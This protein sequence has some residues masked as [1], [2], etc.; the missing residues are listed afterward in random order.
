MN[1]PTLSSRYYSAELLLLLLFG[2]IVFSRIFS[3]EIDK[4]PWLGVSI[5]EPRDMFRALGILQF[6]VFAYMYIEW[7]QCGQSETQNTRENKRLAFAILLLIFSVLLGYP[8]FFIGSYYERLSPWWLAVFLSIACFSG[9]V[10]STIVCALLFIRTK[11]ETRRLGLPKVPII[12]KNV[13]GVGT[14]IMLTICSVLYVIWRYTPFDTKPTVLWLTPVVF[15]ATLIGG[16]LSF[17]APRKTNNKHLS[18]GSVFNKW[19]ETN[20]KCDYL[21]CML[22]STRLAEFHALLE[23]IPK[24]SSSRDLQKVVAEA[25]K[26]AYNE[27]MQIPR[28]SI[29]SVDT[30][31]SFIVNMNY[32]DGITQGND[33]SASSPHIIELSS[34]IK[35]ARTTVVF[36]E[37]PS[38]PKKITLP[39]KIVQECLDIIMADPNS[40]QKFFQM[41]DTL[42]TAIASKDRQS[43]DHQTEEYKSF[44]AYIIRQAV[45]LQFVGNPL[46]SLFAPAING[47]V[48]SIQTVLNEDVDVNEVF[49]A[50]GWTPLM[51]AVAQGH[52]E[53]AKILLRAGANTDIQN[54]QGVTSLMFAILYGNIKIAKL[55]Y[56][57]KANLNKQDIKGDTALMLGI[58]MKNTACVEWLIEIGADVEK[59]NKIGV[60]AIRLAE[61]TKQGELRRKLIL[62]LERQVP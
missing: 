8:L 58:T 50:N 10:F 41:Y 4:I 23:K 5:E 17:F 18:S 12:V 43:I 14:G 28:F 9:L 49:P 26:A 38:K 2:I 45:I 40:R 54:H 31:I 52:Y 32:R 30:P 19:K 21:N 22:D 59:E 53:A 1:K 15:I 55:L 37:S 13:L 20:N 7:W 44:I 34:E 16:S 46:P 6:C 29:A 62:A 60:D 48:A 27:A 24:K 35:R 51:H 36:D 61:Q 11:K 3:L 39:S 25:S 56:R 33:A 47:D 42:T 57:Y